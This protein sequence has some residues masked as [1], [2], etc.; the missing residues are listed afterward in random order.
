MAIKKKNKTST[1]E[2]ADVLVIGAGISGLAAAY[3][4]TKKKKKVIM[5]EARERV[6]GRVWSV[7]L[8]GG[9][10]SEHGAEWI[11]THHAHMRA[12]ANEL[13]VPLEAH[14]YDESEYLSVRTHKKEPLYEVVGKKLD[15]IFSVLPKHAT[16]KEMH[17]LDRHTW[18]HFLARTFTKKELVIANDIY[19]AEYGA[20]IGKVTALLPVHE[21]FTGGKTM[22]MDLHVVGGNSRLMEAIARAVGRRH[23]RLGHV[24]T[25]VVQD[26]Q[27][28][29]VMCENGKVFLA[30]KL[31]V[32]VPL[33]TLRDVSFVPKLPRQIL[34][35]ERTLRYGD[36]IKVILVF[37]KRFWK[38][39]NFAELSSGLAQYVFHTTQSQKGKRGALTV[40]AVGARADTLAKMS[41]S[42]IWKE[43]K[44]ALPKDIDTTGV[45]PGRMFRHFWREDP[46]VQGAYAYYQP[47]QEEDIQKVFAAP[48]LHAYFSG[49]HVG[50]FQGFMEGAAQSGIERARDIIAS[51][52]KQK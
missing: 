28:V 33:T 7:A 5:L 37:P 23:I 51:L 18:R 46:F 9:L 34:S 21:H 10:V 17:A 26:E 4:L 41:M 39:E 16:K 22:H 36:I 6:G 24:V 15:S 19:S 49:E 20:N 38:K 50:R 27:G 40:Y 3:E 52:K 8:G 12:L 1:I 13:G 47:H 2:E 25:N 32:T 14:R 35:Y 29:I 31:L 42:A 45:S 48:F 44:Q 30:K 11:G 43:L